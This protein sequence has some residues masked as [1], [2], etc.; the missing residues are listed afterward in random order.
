[1]SLKIGFF[2]AA[3]FVVDFLKALNSSPHSLEFI[4]T[5]PDRAKGRGKKI[6]PPETK[7]F[8]EDNNIPLFQPE[9]I[10]EREF[11]D[12]ISSFSCDIYLVIAYGKILPKEILYHPP[13]GSLN[14]HFSL[15]PRWRG[16]APVNWAIL[17]G[18]KITGITL[19]KMDE[20]LDTGDIIFQREIEIGEED[21]SEDL[22]KKM[23]E[24]GTPF[25]LDS[26][27]KI[28]KGNFTLKKQEE[29]R[30]TYAKILKKEDGIID[31]RDSAK[32]IHNKVRGLIPWPYA[33]TFLEEK[34]LVILK[35]KILEGELPPG[36]IK[37]FDGEGL[38]V[39][40]GNKVIKIL[41]IKE[42]GKKALSAK[43]YYNGRKDIIGKT[44]R[45]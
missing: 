12:K 40:T 6:L 21:T 39:G 45:I 17:S 36:Y 9:S 32:N 16:A 2:G 41:E 20:G 10:K 8:A 18:D 27:G 26:L 43:D 34:R 11:L 31:W 28:E 33:Y 7:I 13:L 42:E 14:L 23:I 29:E 4:V 1:M 22:F 38:L 24:V 30:S 35:T 5:N 15:L 3:P 44:F 19:M 25:L 37:A